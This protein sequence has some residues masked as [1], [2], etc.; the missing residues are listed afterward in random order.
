M[1]HQCLYWFAR[2][3]CS[4]NSV[5]PFLRRITMI[6]LALLAAHMIGDY[7]M[8]TGWMAANKLQDWRARTVHVSVYSAA[9]VPVVLLTKLNVQM[10]LLFVALVWITHF[11]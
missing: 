8:Q 3:A 7:I 2:R 4:R 6:A 11:I 1:H 5:R 9:F 10:M